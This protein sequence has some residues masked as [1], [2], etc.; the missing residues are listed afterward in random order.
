MSNL[1]YSNFK[2]FRVDFT[3]DPNDRVQPNYSNAQE[4]DSMFNSIVND[5]TLALGNDNVEVRNDLHAVVV[6][7]SKLS[8]V[9]TMNT[10]YGFGFYVLK[11]GMSI[12]RI[13][14]LDDLYD[15]SSNYFVHGQSDCC[16]YSSRYAEEEV[17]HN[18]AYGYD[19][20]LCKSRLTDFNYGNLF[21]YGFSQRGENNNVSDTSLLLPRQR[22]ID[23]L[24]GIFRENTF[25][26]PRYCYGCVNYAF[27]YKDNGTWALYIHQTRPLHEQY[28]VHP[29]DRRF[30]VTSVM[31]CDADVNF[32]SEL[33]ASCCGWIMPQ[34]P[35][36][37]STDKHRRTLKHRNHCWSILALYMKGADSA[38]IDGTDQ[39][40][41]CVDI[42]RDTVDIMSPN[43]PAF[44][45]SSSLSIQPIRMSVVR[46]ITEG[47]KTKCQCQL[48]TTV[49]IDR[50]VICRCFCGCNVL[51]SFAEENDLPVFNIYRSY[52]SL[53]EDPVTNVR[54]TK[55]EGTIWEWDGCG[56]IHRV[57]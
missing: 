19:T 32:D 49:E 5:F 47:D 30:G 43:Y 2:E 14:N 13:R 56:M 9:I 35:S 6:K 11:D 41:I 1:H 45:T 53:K 33:P 15:H 29:N 27:M 12:G 40:K 46:L 57:S 48:S 39:N 8:I 22:P 38:S 4:L 42:K 16:Y 55:S 44:N 24:K 3:C 54:R 52:K 25:Y 10:G 50:D 36:P 17:H 34:G 26:L 20:N 23:D 7:N 51:P 28:D 18:S 31:F 21:S 37:L